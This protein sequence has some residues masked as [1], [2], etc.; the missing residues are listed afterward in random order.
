MS[1]FCE[2]R[3]RSQVGISFPMLGITN[4]GHCRVDLRRK[5]RLIDLLTI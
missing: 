4:C 5:I 3:V 1:H 2:N